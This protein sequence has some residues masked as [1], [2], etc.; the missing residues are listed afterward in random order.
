MRANQAHHRV[1][2]MCRVLGVSPSGYYA[3]RRRGRSRRAKR[4]EELRGTLR[5]IHA[6]SGG[7]YGVPRVHAELSAQGC[8]VG[9]KRVVRLMGEAG[10]AGVS[11]R[12]GTRTTRREPGHRAAPDRVER[13][14]QAHAPD[15]LWVADITYVPTWAGF[16]YLAIVLDGFSRKGV[17]W[18]MAHPLRTER[19]LAALHMAL[20]QRRPEGVVH[21]SDKGTQYPSLAFGKRCREMGVVT[22]IGSAGDGH[23]NAMAESVFATLECERLDRRAFHTQVQARMALFEFIEGWYDTPRR[24]SALGSLSPNDFE[25]A[26]AKAASRAPGNDDR[27]DRVDLEAFRSDEPEAPNHPPGRP[28]TSVF[29]K[30]LLPSAFAHPRAGSESHHLSTQSG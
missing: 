26:A 21:H 19:V 17:G 20:G 28:S 6:A 22:S 13:Q 5:T 30:I 15:R 12:R 1:A 25:R 7:T 4:D 16:V 10:W 24:H 11:R 14:F 29:G 8:G 3:W 23:D 27:L 18:A 2:T 9:R